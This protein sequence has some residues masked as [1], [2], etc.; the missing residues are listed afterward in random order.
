MSADLIIVG[1]GP[2][3]STV[4]ELVARAGFEALIPEKRG[5]PGKK[6]ICGGGLSKTCFADLKLPKETI[7]KE[8]SPW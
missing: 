8:C 2:A 7:E 4:G 6:K 3:G 1:A 5:T